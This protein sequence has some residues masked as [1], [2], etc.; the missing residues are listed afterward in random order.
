VKKGRIIAA[1]VALIVIVGVGGC[2]V[3]RAQASIPTV[4]T[5]TAERG[6]L[7]RTVT[8][9]G[10]TTMGERADVYP[11]TAGTLADVYVEDGQRVEAGDVLAVMDTDPLEAQVSAAETAYLGAVAQ[12]DA[13]EQQVPGASEI[14]AA[15]EQADAALAAYYEAQATTAQVEDA[16]DELRGAGIS[17]SIDLDSIETTDPAVQDAVDAVE[18]VLED[19]QDTASAIG[20]VTLALLDAQVAGLE[21]AENQALAAWAQAE[22]QVTALEN[23]DTSA[24]L[25]SARAGVDQAAEALALARQVLSESTMTAPISGVVVFNTTPS[26][27]GVDVGGAEPGPGYSVTPAA[28]PFTV[29]RLG[30]LEFVGDVDE[31]DVD[32]LEAGMP[33]TVVLDAFPGSE[34]ETEVRKTGVV[35]QLT[36]TGGNAFPVHL[37]LVDTG[38]DILIGMRGSVEIEVERI[39]DTASVPIEALFEEDGRTFVYLLE[40][41]LLARTSVEVGIYTETRVQILSGLEGDEEVVLS[42]S[43]EYSDGMRVRV[44]EEETPRGLGGFLGAQD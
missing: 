22:G 15:Q 7:A 17:D 26:I 42:S 35:S 14:E 28:A 4:S 13:L 18:Q 36:A 19:L 24:S 25:T 10:S 1:V 6:E 44:G 40:D 30:A 8:V 39:A 38:E 16:L 11:P 29:A 2:I 20:G 23:T 27:G 31:A 32:T 41:D 34:F 9:S 21:A 5:S 3:M 33:A 43:V 37:D 12:L